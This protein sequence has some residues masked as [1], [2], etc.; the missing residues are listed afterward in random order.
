MKWNIVVLVMFSVV[1]TLMMGCTSKTPEV[2]ASKDVLQWESS[3]KNFDFQG[4]RIFYQDSKIG[5]NW[6]KTF[7]N[8][9]T[10]N[11]IFP[12]KNSG[13]RARNSFAVTILYSSTYAISCRM[14]DEKVELLNAAR[15][16]ICEK[17]MS[18]NPAVFAWDSQWG[19]RAH[20]V[21]HFADDVLPRRPKSLF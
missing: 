4:N 16:A 18:P 8:R 10:N 6:P 17:K 12:H 19:L 13:P 14:C 5:S 20:F 21:V 9:P 2:N 15:P 11:L 3:G 7:F 1:G